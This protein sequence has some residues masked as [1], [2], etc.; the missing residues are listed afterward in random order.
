MAKFAFL[1]MVNA[2]EGEDRA[3]NAW[4]DEHHIPEVLRTAG[5]RSAA[6]YE[7]PADESAGNPRATH[8]Y[9]HLYEIETDDLAATK[10]ALAAGNDARTPLTPALKTSDMV[11]VFYKAR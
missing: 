9:M 1:V 2:E 11:A 8:K 5:F 4:L 6:R 3:L 7:L 10:A